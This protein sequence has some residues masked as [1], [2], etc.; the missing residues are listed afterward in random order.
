VVA[1][2]ASA[3]GSEL[4]VGLRSRRQLRAVSR[5]RSDAPLLRIGVHLGGF[6]GPADCS[7]AGPATLSLGGSR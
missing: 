2:A 6:A 1:S 5:P 3:M 4:A 7:S